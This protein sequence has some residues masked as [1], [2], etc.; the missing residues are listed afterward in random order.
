MYKRQEVE[1]T[2]GLSAGDQVVT[3]GT[4]SQETAATKDTDKQTVSYTHLDV[5]KRQVYQQL[6]SDHG[7]RF[8]KEEAD[9]AVAH[10]DDPD[11]AENSEGT[12]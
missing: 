1:V 2:S 5:Y 8:T 7:E 10:M 4:I 9:Y 11:N 12:N 6:T 3:S